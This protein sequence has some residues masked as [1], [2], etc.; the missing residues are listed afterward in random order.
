MPSTAT[1]GDCIDLSS[2][3]LIGREKKTAIDENTPLD[4]TA[5][6][7]RFMKP[8]P[9]REVTPLLAGQTGVAIGAPTDA[10]ETPG[11]TIRRLQ[12]RPKEAKENINVSGSPSPTAASSTSSPAT[13][14]AGH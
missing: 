5:I 13:P 8:S 3:G 14:P 9:K 12:L 2:I 6:R 7:A 10:N 11:T 4:V 1:T